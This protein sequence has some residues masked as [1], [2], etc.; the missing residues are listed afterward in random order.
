MIRSSRFF[1]THIYMISWLPCHL[2]DPFGG[3][4]LC[5]VSIDGNKGLFPV[6]YAVVEV[7]C[8]DS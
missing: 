3:I 6:A 5:I 4:L 7:E 1:K 2:K 8:K